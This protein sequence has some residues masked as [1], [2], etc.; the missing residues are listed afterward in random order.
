[1]QFRELRSLP[2]SI[3]Q[4]MINTNPKFNER[5]K[6]QRAGAAGAARDHTVEKNGLVK[7]G[8][9]GS[10]A[11]KRF[12]CLTGELIFSNQ[13]ADFLK[14]LTRRESPSGSQERESRTFHASRV[15]KVIC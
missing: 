14:Q 12:L 3:G 2:K 8:N 13:P 10:D 1:L 15:S 5:T 4:A 7:R 6:Q 11:E 9:R